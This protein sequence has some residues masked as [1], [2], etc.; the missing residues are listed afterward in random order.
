MISDV[1]LASGKHAQIERISSIRPCDG[2]A[3]GSLSVDANMFTP[4]LMHISYEKEVR[5]RWYRGPT[6]ALG[7]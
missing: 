7:H 5:T 4:A 6:S 2:R 1:E 3:L